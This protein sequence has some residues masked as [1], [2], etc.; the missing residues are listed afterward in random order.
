[1][2]TDKKIEKVG[3]YTLH[4][5]LGS[6]G[7]GAVYLGRHRETHRVAAVKILASSL[8]QEEGFVERFNREIESLKR[9]KNP[10]I[11]EL[12]DSGVDEGTYYYAMEYVAGE[13]LTSVI[14]RER[15]LPWDR[16]I[17]IGIQICQALKAAHDAGVVHRDLKP[18]NLLLTPEGEV[19]LADFGVA[20]IFASQRLTVTGG[21]VG[22]AEYMSPEQAQGHRATKKS[23]LYSLGAVLYVLLTGR[24][25]FSGSTTVEVL[26][27]HRYARFDPPRLIVPDIPHWLDDAICQLL[28]KDPDKRPPDAFVV[29][30]MLD[31]IRRKVELVGSETTAE[32]RPDGSAPTRVEQQSGPGPATMMKHLVRAELNQSSETLWAKVSNSIITQITLLFLIVM[33]GV[34]WFQ[35][36]DISDDEK[37]DRG[38]KLMKTDSMDQWE[39]A[40]IMYFLPLLQSD[41]DTWEPRVR[42]YLNKIE[43]KK[44]V[45]KP[46]LAAREQKPDSDPQRFFN[47]ARDLRARGDLVQSEKLLSA[48]VVLMEQE[49]PEDPNLYELASS[50]LKQWQA[51]SQ[52]RS[53][54][55]AWVEKLLQKAEDALSKPAEDRASA[56]A[57]CDSILS[58]YEQDPALKKQVDAA[59]KLREQLK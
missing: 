24:A 40:R 28:E 41:R 56:R 6:G 20:Q 48:L 55:V 22:T 29:S 21:I 19:K 23:D 26:Q 42:P 11:V 45:R 17:D 3:P 54:D 50:L 25:P 59:R 1:M 33:G 5:K 18:S 32:L 49:R 36:I 4:E 15:R 2:S 14:K 52:D 37:F 31:Q 53:R 57:T 27:K 9:V 46:K 58:L 44:I 30:R 35:K 13:T 8:A 39:E 7:M 38:V 34:W 12:Y 16:V 47:L 10:H 43:V 51:E